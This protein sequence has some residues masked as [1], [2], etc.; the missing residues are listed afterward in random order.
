NLPGA[1]GP[2]DLSVA[3]GE[4]VALVGQLGSGADALLES[5]TGL[6][7]GTRGRLELDGR[8][9][10]LRGIA[11]AYLAGIAYVAEDRAGKGVFLDAPIGLNLV[12]Q[13]LGTVSPGGWVSRRLMRERAG[14]LAKQFQ[15]DPSRLPHEV[16]TLSGGNQQKVSLGKAVALGPRLLLLN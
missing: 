8:S 4:I 13:V 12:S 1:S 11:D 3:R 16:S 15:I 9:V 10:E 7:R 5:M 6:H 14:G 2:F